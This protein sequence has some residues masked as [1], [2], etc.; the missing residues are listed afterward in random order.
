LAP[1]STVIEAGGH[2]VTITNPD[3]VFFPRLG[4][5]KLDLVRYYEAVA[6]GALR[7]V[8]RRPMVL[9][10]FVN[11]AEEEPFFQKRAPANLPPWIDTAR[12]HF[13][14]GRFADL[15]VADEP[16]DVLWAVNLGC[17]DL[18]P[19]PVRV[20][21]VDRPDELRI[22]LDPTPDATFEH[23]K[24]TAMLAREVLEEYGYRAFAK[25]SGSRGIHVYIRIQPR[26][27]FGVVRRA[28][29]ALAREIERRNPALVTT[30]WWKEERHGVFIDY[31][32]NAR[33]RTVASA[34]SV[35][36]TPDARVSCPVTWEELP[37][38]Q[39]EDFT[40]ASVPERFARIGDPMAAIDDEAFSL[41]PLIELTKRHEDEGLGD[42]PWP[43][44]F[45][46]ADGEPKRVQP[47]RARK[48]GTELPTG[49]RQ[50]VHPLITVAKAQHKEEAL[51]GLERWKQRHP[52][53]AASLQPSDVLVDSMRGMSSTWTRIRLNLRNVP[54]D[55]RPPEEPPDPDYDPWAN[56]PP[57]MRGRQTKRVNPRDGRL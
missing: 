52:E 16:A 18:N 43:P 34:Y 35:R 15:V 5:T 41:E 12:V 48:D 36:P 28:G 46:K 17:I 57:E 21:D 25:T 44:Q 54:E 38:V 31:N 45:P 20:D 50:S 49:R 11:G 9:K 30:A 32:Q 6:E 33:D 53:A 27:E 10:R 19:W 2:E 42:A 13:P 24:Q 8:M 47:S 39:L 56:L 1:K 37:G 51:A 14:S 4:L 23:V 40:V 3:K 29:V 55:K 7:G 26:W 22:D